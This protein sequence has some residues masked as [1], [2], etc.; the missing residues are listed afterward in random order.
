M[1]LDRNVFDVYQINIYPNF[2]LLYEVHAATTSIIPKCSKNS[3]NYTI[4]E[5]K[6]KLTKFS[7]SRRGTILRNTVLVA[8]LKA[9][10]KKVLLTRDNELF[11][12]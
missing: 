6:M 4:F 1:I 8:A 10:A 12:F 9:K 11:F 7:I 5:S 3:G 2:I